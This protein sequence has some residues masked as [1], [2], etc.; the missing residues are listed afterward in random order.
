[1]VVKDGQMWRRVNSRKVRGQW[2]GFRDCV[3][4]EELDNMPD[5]FITIDGKVPKNMT[6]EGEDVFEL[7]PV[8]RKNKFW[9]LSHTDYD[10][11]YSVRQ[12]T[13]WDGI[14]HTRTQQY[15]HNNQ[16]QWLEKHMKELCENHAKETP[17]EYDCRPFFIP[18]DE[19]FAKA[20]YTVK[21][22]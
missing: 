18:N 10:Y 12:Y 22:P 15:C 11:H 7:W 19:R 3:K 6:G 8:K 14:L 4:F 13:Y 20:R 21:Q 2:Y 1:M 5:I 16:I 17:D 9:E